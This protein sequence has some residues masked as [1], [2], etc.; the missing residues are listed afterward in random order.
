[1]FRQHINP[2]DGIHKKEI[3]EVWGD[4]I[5]M[6]ARQG[7]VVL[8]LIEDFFKQANLP[9]DFTCRRHTVNEDGR[10]FL[11]VEWGNRIAHIDARPFGSHLDVYAILALRRGL[12]DSPDPNTRISELDGVERRDL[13]VFQTLL[14]HAVEQSLA[15]FEEGSAV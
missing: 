13:Q 5:E 3:Y 4:I 1:M 2:G 8:N 12:I 6:A 10:S 14:H 15:V 7:Q 11:V 9:E